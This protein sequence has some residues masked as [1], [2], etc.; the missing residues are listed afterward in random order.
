MRKVKKVRFVHIPIKRRER[1]WGFFFV[2]I[3]YTNSL[4]V[5]LHGLLE[6]LRLH[7]VVALRLELLGL[8]LVL[9]G[10]GAGATKLRKIQ[11]YM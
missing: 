10:R 1:I 11:K 7:H 6:H 3:Y 8:G 5:Q 9:C 4:G 2:E